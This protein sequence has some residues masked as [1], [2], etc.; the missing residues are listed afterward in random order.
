MTTLISKVQYQRSEKG[1]FHQIVARNLHDTIAILLNYPWD[2]ERQLASVEL[3]CPS[4]TIEHPNGT[5]L[6]VGPYF[7]GKFSLYYL[8]TN[9]KIYL[10]AVSTLVEAGEWLKIFFDQEGK[11]EGFEK[12]GFTINGDAHFRTNPFEYKVDAKAIRIFFRF[13]IVMMPIIVLI[14][15]GK[16]AAGPGASL[17]GLFIGLV[18]IMLLL[19]CPLLFFFFN[20]LLADKYDYLQISKGHDEFVYR[21]ATNTK[22]YNKQNVTEIIAYGVQSSRSLWNNCE[23][24]KITFNSGEQ[25]K[26]T[27][28]LI[29]GRKLRQKLP[30]QRIQDVFKFF[31]TF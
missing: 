24:Y 19:T 5:F 4:V 13:P 8:D 16:Y 17:I 10:K 28:L 30:D 26:F 18:F 6:K 22:I 2:T 15:F 29:S 1:E 7:S 20:Y 25:I 27:S 31:P 23:V 12:Y 9:H 11:L 3:T 14:G 21:K